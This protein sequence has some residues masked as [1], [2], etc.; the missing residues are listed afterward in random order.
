MA[1]NDV[2]R[3]VFVNLALT[4]GPGFYGGKKHD[5][6]EEIAEVLA[7]HAARSNG[8]LAETFLILEKYYRTH[9]G[10][11]LH[12]LAEAPDPTVTGSKGGHTGGTNI[13]FGN[14]GG[15]S[16]DGGGVGYWIY[17]NAQEQ[18]CIPCS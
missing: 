6:N 4:I 10:L 1:Q 16:P 17:V 9:L 11:P 5:T 12:Q 14:C 18:S 3:K 7:S 8:V 2:D 15:C 13:T